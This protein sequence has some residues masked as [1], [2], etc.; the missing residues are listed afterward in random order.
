M[1]SLEMSALVLPN[2][3]PVK[4]G[5]PGVAGGA[6]PVYHHAPCG[7][8][9]GGAFRDVAGCWAASTRNPGTLATVA[10]KIRKRLLIPRVSQTLETKSSLTCCLLGYRMILKAPSPVLGV[11]RKS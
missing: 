5:G 6:S 1:A 8:G 11:L 7:L 9:L 3:T 2:Q 4:S 10:N